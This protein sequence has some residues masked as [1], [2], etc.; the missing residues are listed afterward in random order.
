MKPPVLFSTDCYKL[1]HSQQYPQGTE[2]VQSNLT[3]RTSRVEGQGSVVFFGL[4]YFLH[5]YLGAAFDTFFNAPLDDIL[6]DYQARTTAILGPNGIG[7]SHIE[8]LWRLQYVPIVIRAF[9]EGSVVPIG[10]PLLTIENTHPGFGWLVNYLETLLSATTWLSI[11]TATSAMRMRRILESGAKA[12]GVAPEFVDWQAHDFSFRGMGGLEA[13]QMS[14]AAHLVFFTGSDTIPAMDFLQQ[15]YEIHPD[16]LIMGSVA[17]T[18]H[19]VMCAGGELTEMETFDRL[20]DTY[21]TG[22]VSIVSD[23]WD[24]WKVLTGILPALKDKILGREGKLVLRPDSGDPVNI[25][26]GNPD[27]LVAG[28]PESKGVIQLLWDEFGGTTNAAG[29]RTLDA[30]VGAIYGDSITH[31]RAKRILSRLKDAG[32]ASDNIIFGVGS[33]TYQFVTRDTYGMAV[34]ATWAQVNGEGRDLYKDPVTDSGIKRSARGRLAV[35]PNEVGRPTLINQATRSQENE[36]LLIEA[37]RDGIVSSALSL[38]GVRGRA[39]KEMEASW[40]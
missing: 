16:T 4:Q 7:T 2:Y 37:W 22:I 3:A 34:K 30:H 29:F 13:A 27:A 18:E 35:L 1:G 11:T 28:S 15:N 39:R 14:G 9:P 21:P 25:I 23:T 12:T 36:S 6:R 31:D 38:E 19:S 40:A 5:E 32:F 8:A 33:F 24:L 26:C 10:V 17:A 20:L